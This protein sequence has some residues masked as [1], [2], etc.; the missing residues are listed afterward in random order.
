M[1]DRLVV[2]LFVFFRI[3]VSF[4]LNIVL[5]SF[6]FILYKINKFWGFFCVVNVF[7]IY[8]LDEMKLFV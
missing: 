1:F 2:W 6:L 3:L 8:F 7:L 5:F 4:C